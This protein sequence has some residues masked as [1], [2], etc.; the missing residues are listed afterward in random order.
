[1]HKT[2]RAV[3]RKAVIMTSSAV[4]IAIGIT[5]GIVNFL[6]LSL[7]IIAIITL[8][9]IDRAARLS[10]NMTLL[11]LSF[12]NILQCFPSLIF[13]TTSCFKR[14]WIWKASWCMFYAV[15]TYWLA[16]TA[17]YMKML[18]AWQHYSIAT[19]KT[20]VRANK[21][22]VR[23]ATPPFMCAMLALFWCSLP[24]LGWSSYG[25]EGIL[26]SCS[27]KWDVN[28]FSH[29][30]YNMSTM[31]VAFL[32]PIV[33]IVTT[34]TRVVIFIRRHSFAPDSNNNNQAQQRAELTLIKVGSAVTL[35]FLV[36][37]SPYAVTSILTI[38]KPQIVTP[39]SQTIPSIVAK[40]STLALPLIYLLIHK[41]F[42]KEVFRMLRLL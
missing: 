27:L 17:I 8:C 9:K 36:M 1:M 6:S 10:I 23:R 24:L 33:F 41:E 2:R 42:R 28:D 11:G 20:K 16:L 26:V 7:N 37:W 34:Y 19:S 40:A 22:F 39:L 4:Y 18:L 32:L 35:L 5:N 29:L 31:V 38:A 25:F 30:S 12:D 13:V 21:S 14:K 15:W 3:G